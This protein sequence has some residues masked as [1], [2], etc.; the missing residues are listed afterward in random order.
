GKEI[1][2]GVSGPIGIMQ[3]IY[4][5]SHNGLAA[6]LFFLGLLNAAVG[7]FNLIPFPALDGSRLLILMVAGLRGR[8]FDP[9]KEA[10]FH[11]TGLVILLTLVIFVTFFDVQRLFA[12]SLPIE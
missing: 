10:R 4:V 11:F 3:T 12:G 8:E 9:D 1:A 2:Q 5:I 7:G 6:F